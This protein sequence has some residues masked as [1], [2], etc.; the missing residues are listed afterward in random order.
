MY[1]FYKEAQDP[2]VCGGRASLYTYLMQEEDQRGFRCLN[3][4]SWVSVNPYMG[5]DNRNHC[6]YCLWT[7]HVDGE[8]PGDRMSNCRSGMKPI[9]LTF[10]KSGLSKT[11]DLRQ[12]EIMIVHQC[13]KC[14][15]LCINR[16][17]AD[18]NSNEILK[19]FEKSLTL[20][21]GTKDI[22]KSQEIEILTEKNR[23]ELKTQL[24][25]KSNPA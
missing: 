8:T 18:D 20:D 12:G 17:A 14:G 7:K 10:K 21:E 23:D 19:T 2:V 15:K 25:G 11:G 16:I 22:L 13:L 24:F 9:A 4:Q 6:S 1:S 3:C 5:T